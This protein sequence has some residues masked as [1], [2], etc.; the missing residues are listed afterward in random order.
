MTTGFENFKVFFISRVITS[1]GFFIFVLGS[2]KTF[3]LPYCFL[4]FSLS[5]ILGNLYCLNYVLKERVLEKTKERF[6][7]KRIFL[8]FSIPMHI[9]SIPTYLGNF[10]VPILSLFFP[11]ELIGQ[12]SFSFLFYYGGLIIPSSFSSV[13]LPKISKLKTLNKEG[14]IREN[15]VKAL[16][17][18]TIVVLIGI[19]FILLFG[20]TVISIIA[21][22]YLPGLTFFKVLASFGLLSG[23]INIYISYLVAKE[24]IGLIAI[25]TLIQHVLLFTI[26][27]VMLKLA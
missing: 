25:M 6:D 22:Q 5:F 27:F 8:K 4:G 20:R 15:L 14:K 10:I 12:Y 7:V 9:L 26:S 23:Y 18:Y 19:F 17:A 2:A 3:G 24:K 13:L 21:P 11:I 16:M 1:V